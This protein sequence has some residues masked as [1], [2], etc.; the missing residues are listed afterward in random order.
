MNKTYIFLTILLLTAMAGCEQPMRAQEQLLFIA[1]TETG[2]EEHVTLEVLFL[3]DGTTNEMVEFPEFEGTVADSALHAVRFSMSVS[4]SLDH[5]AWI[6]YP[7]E[8][9]P[10][11]NGELSI[12]TIQSQ[13]EKGIGTMVTANTSDGIHWSPDSVY[14][15]YCSYAEN[16]P[17][18]V[19]VYGIE[20]EQ[21]IRTG[22]RE[23]PCNS[24]AWD[25]NAQ[26]IAVPTSQNQVAVYDVVQQQVTDMIDIGDEAVGTHDVICNPQWS[27]DSKFLVFSHGCVMQGLGNLDG[28]EVFLYSIEEKTLRSLVTFSEPEIEKLYSLVPSFQYTWYIQ[29]DETY[30]AVMFACTVAT[31]LECLDGVPGS[32]LQIYNVDSQQSSRRFL[33]IGDFHGGSISL[34]L[35]GILVWKT[36]EGWQ[37]GQLHGLDF[38]MIQDP[39]YN[40]LPGNCRLPDWNPSGN[41]IAFSQCGGEPDYIYDFTDQKLHTLDDLTQGKS[42][43][44][45]WNIDQSR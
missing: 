23:A 3:G 27:P 12:V 22:I 6:T 25:P 29:D 14:V 7:N 26:L 4:P 8:P 38:E 28:Y 20:S 15:A 41:Y 30:L 31:N 13:E 45:S 32:F 43:F 33:E 37:L 17:K 39:D 16:E 11:Q 44:L 36:E 5:Y 34:S 35:Q 2:S 9:I 18:E 40:D 10:L 21:L 42:M 24:I 19:V 1:Q